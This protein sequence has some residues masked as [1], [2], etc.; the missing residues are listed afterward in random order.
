MLIL[1]FNMARLCE[2]GPEAPCQLDHHNSTVAAGLSPTNSGNSTISNASAS[3]A[4]TDTEF[5]GEVV[6]ASAVMAAGTDADAAFT[7][8]KNAG[9]GGLDGAVVGCAGG[10]TVAGGEGSGCGGE[11]TAPSS[12]ETPRAAAAAGATAASGGAGKDFGTTA[13]AAAAA[14]EP[15]LGG[16]ADRACETREATTNSTPVVGVVA[17]AV[18]ELSPNFSV[19]GPAAGGPAAPDTAVAAVA[20]GSG[21]GTTGGGGGGAQQAKAQERC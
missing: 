19:A 12:N 21:G 4:E 20:K 7:P 17:I 5:V 11:G 18:D 16:T 6:M 14:T 10:R 2:P 3:A 9:D 1:T 8:A 15:P 13:A